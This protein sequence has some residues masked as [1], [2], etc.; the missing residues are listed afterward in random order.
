M[1]TK[2]SSFITELVNILHRLD[3]LLCE[4]ALALVSTLATL[5]AV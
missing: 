3:F 4:L 1:Q 5:L 2:G